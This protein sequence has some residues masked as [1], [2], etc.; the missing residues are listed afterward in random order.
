VYVN[1]DVTLDT[2]SSTY[3]SGILYVEG[4]Y[5]QRAPS[6]VNGTVMVNGSVVVSGLG[7]YSEINFDPDVR[8]RVL[9]VSGQYRFSTPMYF[10]Q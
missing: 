2:N 10:V 1:G 8:S 9:S 3:F 7:D 6:L 5:V 4:D